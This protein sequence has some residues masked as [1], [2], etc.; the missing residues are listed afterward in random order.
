[1]LALGAHGDDAR[2]LLAHAAP[3]SCSPLPTLTHIPPFV[4]FVDQEDEVREGGGS[5]G[6]GAAGQDS[7]KE[8]GG[9][10]GANGKGVVDMV[11]CIGRLCFVDVV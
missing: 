10:E 2:R 9:G 8:G 3:Q 11:S 7:G 5:A 6:S 1:M 4:C